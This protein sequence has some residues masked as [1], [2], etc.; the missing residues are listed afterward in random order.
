MDKKSEPVFT[1]EQ[2]AKAAS[3]AD[4]GFVNHLLASGV[5]APKAKVLLKRATRIV[6]DTQQRRSQLFGAVK[7]HVTSIR[8]AAS[9]TPA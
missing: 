7:D 1:D 9:P 8:S 3:H 5:E 4:R 6:A 2:Q